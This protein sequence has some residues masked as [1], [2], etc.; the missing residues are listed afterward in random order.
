MERDARCVLD[1]EHAVVKLTRKSLEVARHDLSTFL[2]GGDFI[3]DTIDDI[4]DGVAALVEV[5]DGIVQEI[6]EVIEPLF[7]SLAADRYKKQANQEDKTYFH[8]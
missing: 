6:V 8:L 2:V 4:V 5:F 1:W 3:D 7:P